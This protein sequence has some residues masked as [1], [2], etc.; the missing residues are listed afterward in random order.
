MNEETL[1]ND[2]MNDTSEEKAKRYFDNAREV[3]AARKEAGTEKSCEAAPQLKGV[4]FRSD[5]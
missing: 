2:F 3:F 5:S 1:N 4:F